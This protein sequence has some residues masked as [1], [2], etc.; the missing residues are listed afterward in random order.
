MFW[1]VFRVERQNLWRDRAAW[2][3]LL[4]FFLL[5]AYAAVG[6]ARFAA[7]ERAEMAA[8]AEEETTRLA[9]L[10][11]RVL[12]IESGAPVVHATDPREP[13][14][15]GR[16]LGKRAATLPPNALGAVSLGQRDL[17]P[18]TIWITT[19]ARL[20]EAGSDDGGS[21]NRRVTGAFDLAFVV[22]FLLP[23]VVIALCFDVLAAERERGT[24][25][26]VLSQPV[27]LGTFVFAK[28]L[29]RGL[30]LLGVVLVAALVVPLALVDAPFDIQG[31]SSVALYA[32][33]LVAYTAFWVC[34]CACVNAYGTS[35]AG[36]A[37]SLVSVWLLLVVV[38]P[39]LASAGADTL[40][41]SPSRVELVNRAREVARE[42]EAEVSA[43][44]G[45]H[46]QPAAAA[47]DTAVRAARVQTEL[48]H[49]VE[50]VMDAFRA[51]LSRQQALVDRLRF[52]SPAIVAYEGLNDVAGTGVTRHQHFSRAV[53]RYHDEY[54]RF[55]FE[56][57]EQRQKLTAADYDALPRFRY[58]EAPTA[59]LASRLGAGLLGLVLPSAAL[60]LLARRGFRRH[61]SRGLR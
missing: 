57:M 25:A 20:S 45:D 46:G 19:E 39:G 56:R 18:H 8:T 55:F 44:E 17:L 24:L 43:I 11:E 33:L 49:R 58:D 30:V 7:A 12:A 14:L 22:V 36:N 10:R 42:V 50:P 37:L 1:T 27:G 38:V 48:E 41:P 13:A 28:A 4:G 32:A 5:A 15:V 60:L 9:Q 40:Y 52:L 21:L 54:K 23:L 2:A 59:R 31:A 61:F 6:G 53:E 26:L 34:L 16:D 29:L 3:V 35:S 47:G 51:Q